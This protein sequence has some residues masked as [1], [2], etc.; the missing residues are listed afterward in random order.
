MTSRRQVAFGAAVQP[1][2]TTRAYVACVLLLIG[3]AA[4]GGDAAPTHATTPAIERSY[5]TIVEGDPGLPTHTIY[6]PA[7]LDAVEG[8]LPIVAW[9]TAAA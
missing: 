5:P 9:P 8:V 7:D 1:L 4:C 6:R 3:A 2:P